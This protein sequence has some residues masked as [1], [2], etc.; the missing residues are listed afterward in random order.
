MLFLNIYFTQMIFV[1]INIIYCKCAE[2]FYIPGCDRASAMSGN[3]LSPWDLTGL[4]MGFGLYRPR[5][6]SY[7][8]ATQ[9]NRQRSES[10]RHATHCEAECIDVPPQR[11]FIESVLNKKLEQTNS[12][13]SKN[14]CHDDNHIELN[15]L[16]D[17]HLGGTG[18][19]SGNDVLCET[20]NHINQ[21]YAAQHSK[22][23]NRQHSQELAEVSQAMVVE[24]G[25]V[26]PS[27]NQSRSSTP[28]GGI[29]SFK[30][31]LV[32]LSVSFIL[33]FSSF[34]GVQNLQSSLNAQ[35]QLG[36]IAMS[37]VHGAMVLTCL[38]SPIW[39]SIFTAK[40][41]MGLGSLCFLLWFG[42]N[43]Y[44]TFY[45]LIPASVIAGFGHGLLWTAETSY[46]LQLSFDSIRKG[47]HYQE[48]K[49]FRYHAVFL[50]CFQTTHI[51]GNLISSLLFGQQSQVVQYRSR[52]EEE[53]ALTNNM[54][55]EEQSRMPY[56]SQ[57]GVLY[58]C[59]REINIPV[60]PGKSFGKYAYNFF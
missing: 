11:D 48:H 60:F 6:P 55:S 46:I 40:W 52:Q 9:H 1:F 18:E 31:N 41:T 13:A 20:Q 45:T 30:K 44:P 22:T 39:T 3:T 10:Y 42:A 58:Q 26:I 36:I 19:S 17:D 57:C 14:Y 33:I 37:C 59:Q 8:F 47:R 27:V 53:A 29:I 4:S 38:L 56:I 32:V 54:T 12:K 15:R 21:K 5:R 49:I 50:A 24:V 16:T 35:D 23:N 7:T 2:L 43:F 51:W 34:R 28:S 25:I